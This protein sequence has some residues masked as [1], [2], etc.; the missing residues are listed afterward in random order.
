MLYNDS[1]VEGICVMVVVMIDMNNRCLLIS[2]VLIGFL[3]GVVIVGDVVS[4]IGNG[5]G[6]VDEDLVLGVMLIVDGCC[7]Q[8]VGNQVLFS[9]CGEGVEIILYEVLVLFGFGLIMI[10]LW[11]G[12]FGVF[13]GWINEIC[14]QGDLICVVLVQVFSFVNLLIML[15]ILVGGVGQLVYVMY[16]IFEFW[17]FD[18]ELV[19]EWMLNWVY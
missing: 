14:V 10:G 13:D 15:N 3:Q 16:V 9:L 1:W 8:G 4:D 7:Q 11:L 19:I 6:F 2:Y 12:G 5:W 17:N 18:G